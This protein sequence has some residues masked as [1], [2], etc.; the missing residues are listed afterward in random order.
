MGSPKRLDELFERFFYV[1]IF[2]LLTNHLKQ[3]LT[4]ILSEPTT[5]HVTLS[6]QKKYQQ[7]LSAVNNHMC[8]GDSTFTERG[9]WHCFEIYA[10]WVLSFSLFLFLPFLEAFSRTKE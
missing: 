8:T 3:K 7:M 9:I 2:E 5:Y 6:T 1:F 10:G 4:A